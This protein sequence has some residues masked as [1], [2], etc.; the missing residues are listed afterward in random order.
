MD[1][2]NELYELKRL[3]IRFRHDWPAVFSTNQ[4]HEIW[5]FLQWGHT[6]GQYREPVRGIGKLLDEVAD[7]S[8]AVR[9]GGGRFFI[10]AAHG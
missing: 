3:M 10:G 5:P 1:I 6:A 4:H 7:E 2:A 9:T 8:L